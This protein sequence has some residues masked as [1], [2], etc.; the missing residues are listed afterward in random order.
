MS[1]SEKITK[2]ILTPQEI[3]AL[4]GKLRSKMIG[5]PIIVDDWQLKETH[6]LENG[7]VLRNVHRR[8]TCTGTH[9]SI[10]NPSDHPLKDAP[11]S[12]QLNLIWRTCDH[13]YDHPDPDSIASVIDR[14]GSI[15]LTHYCCADNCCG[16][17]E[18]IGID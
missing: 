7:D 9:C 6:T 11:R 13:G 16:L 18:W 3:E 4:L 5:D 8:G 2:K 17:P 12:W 14:G 15:D 1:E 10:H